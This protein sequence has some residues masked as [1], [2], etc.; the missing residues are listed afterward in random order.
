MRSIFS[1]RWLAALILVLAVPVVGVAQDADTE[2]ETAADESAPAAV[3]EPVEL[4]AQTVTGSRLTT[5]DATARVYSITA[6]DIKRLGVSNVEELMRTLPW[7]YSSITQQTSGLENSALAPSD[8]D[9]NLR[10]VDNL[11][12]GLILFE[13]ITGFGT[14]TV[15]LRALG[16]AN[17]LVLINGRRIAGRAG[18]EEGFANLLN[19]PLSAIER[20]DIQLDGGSAVYGADAIGG[21]INFITKRNYTGAAVTL[22]QDFSSTDADRTNASIQ[23]GYGWGGRPDHGDVAADLA[24]SHFQRQDR[25]DHQ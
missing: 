21:V 6:E 10:A 8:V 19:V 17:T 7:T 12:A 1:G 25:M 9:K 23:G 16:S 14:S 11:A 22:R 5:G 4:E 13:V 15:N 3:E 20:V 2:E 24:R 18:D